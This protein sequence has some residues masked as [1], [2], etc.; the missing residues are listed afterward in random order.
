MW[1]IKIKVLNDLTITEHYL[2]AFICTDDVFRHTYLVTQSSDSDACNPLRP[3]PW[4]HLCI[5][6]LLTKGRAGTSAWQER[7][8]QTS[9]QQS[10]PVGPLRWICVWLIVLENNG[11]T[12]FFVRCVCVWDARDHWDVTH[13]SKLKASLLSIHGISH[14]ACVMDRGGELSVPDRSVTSI[15]S[16]SV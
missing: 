9:P 12:V 2:T 5:P 16:V 15:F 6:A 3:F 1:K 8:G 7:R 4:T 10:Q 11:R 13:A 14:H